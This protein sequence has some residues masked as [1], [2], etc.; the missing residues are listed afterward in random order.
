MQGRNRVTYGEYVELIKKEVEKRT[1]MRVNV[2]KINK[3]NGLLLDGLVIMSEESNVAPNIYLNGYFERFLAYGKEAVAEEIVR[4]YEENKPRALF[5]I[6]I[7]TEK[8]KVSPLIKM[9]IINYEKNKELLEKVPHKRVLDLAVV[10]M[11]V[12]KADCDGSFGTI[13]IHNQHL[14]FWDMTADD[15]YGL[16]EANMA[17]DFEIVSMNK[18]MEDMLENLMDS[19]LEGEV[20]PKPELDMY[21]LT[22]H[23]RLHGAVG[24]LHTELLNQ[25]MQNYRM[26]KIVILPSS[27]HEVLLIPYDD[28]MEKIDFEEMV[29]EVN[30]TELAP[31]EILS[32]SVYLYNGN[33]LKIL[34]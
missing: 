1:G 24:M 27:I 23:T 22:T 26:K 31:E 11:V 33:E 17:D 28:S 34:K 10:F 29:K 14:S 21:V 8:E 4:V 5:D 32:D 16:A 19:A 20:T 13:L 3:N 7:F 2:Q 18:I 30:G 6:S 15:L 12:L 25:F 9:K